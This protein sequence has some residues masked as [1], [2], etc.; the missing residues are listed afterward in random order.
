MPSTSGVPRGQYESDQR[1]NRLEKRRYDRHNDERWTCDDII[2]RWSSDETDDDNDEQ[3]Q[4][5]LQD[6]KCTQS[7]EQ[8][9]A[10]D[11]EWSDNYDDESI[12]D[13]V[14]ANITY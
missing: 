11:C 14:L 7:L 3:S 4:R 9:Y 2:T 6:M 1:C 8:G 10:G 13:I 12:P 5:L